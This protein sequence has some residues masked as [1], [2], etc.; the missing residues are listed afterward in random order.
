[1]DTSEIA[2]DIVATL[3]Y[4]IDGCEVTVEIIFR[5]KGMP[6]SMFFPAIKQGLATGCSQQTENLVANA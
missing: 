3:E 6:S 5:T 4:T 1:M 2:R